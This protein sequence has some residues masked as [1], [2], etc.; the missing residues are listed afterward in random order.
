MSSTNFQEDRV[1]DPVRIFES[2]CQQLERRLVRTALRLVNAAEASGFDRV[3]C[4][5]LRWQCWMHLGCWESAW[6]ESD[7]IAASGRSDPSRVW[8]G[9]S[10]AGQRVLVRGLHGLGDTIQFL[11]FATHLRSSARSVAL[12]VHPQLVSLVREVD[13]IDCAFTWG[14]RDPEWDVQREMTELPRAFRAQQNS[15]P[16]AVPYVRVPEERLVWARG[17]IGPRRLSRIG[18]AWTAGGW[19]PTRSIPLEQFAPLLLLPCNVYCLQKGADIAGS[20]LLELESFAPDVL[21]TAA[22]ILQL[23]LVITVDTM[24]AHLAGAVGVPV[25]ILLPFQADWRWMLGRRDSPWYPT[26]RLF[27]QRRPGEWAPVIESV[28]RSLRSVLRP[29]QTSWRRLRK[30]LRS[31][32]M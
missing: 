27:R 1:H 25:W 13:G 7:A 26:A 11:R 4:A 32:R 6:R 18:L 14:Q 15:I 3:E 31:T 24:T 28:R 2:A 16:A 8:D 20:S 5:A 29:S 12:Q 19:N 30:I 23:D 17:V 10:W 22:L 21:H 9:R